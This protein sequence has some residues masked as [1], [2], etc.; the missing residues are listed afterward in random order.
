MP[1]VQP[2]ELW[3]RVRALGRRSGRSC[4]ASRTATTATIVLG[5][6]H[7]EVD[8]RHRAPRAQELPPAAGQL[9]P[10]PDQVPRRDPAALRRHARA[11]V[12]HEGRLLA[13]TPTRPRCR[14]ATGRCTTPTAR[15]SRASACASVPCTPTA[16]ASAAAPRRNST[17]SRTRARTPSR[18]PDG[19]DYAAN[20]ELAVAAAGRAIRA[21]RPRR[22]H[23]RDR[24]A[25]RAHDR[26][27]RVA[28][29]SSHAER[30]PQDAARRWRRRRTR[31]AASLRGDHELNA[32]S[33]PSRSQRC[34]REAPA[35]WRRP[36]RIAAV[37]RQRARIPR[38]GRI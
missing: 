21:R 11:R 32:S 25:R 17:C 37:A 26:G 1:S 22:G 38:P 33:R 8:H 16:A 30:L 19:D 20:L 28:F 4:C 2:A 5:P 3:Q 29:S 27:R 13:S 7:E 14:R 10:D 34:G 23:A 9:L 18:S 36:E 12:H 24:D 35:A 15:S 6:T 31:G